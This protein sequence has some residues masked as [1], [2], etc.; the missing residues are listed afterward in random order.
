MDLKISTGMKLNQN[1]NIF[2][3]VSL[4]LVAGILRGSKYSEPEIP[5]QKIL[6]RLLPKVAI[7][8]GE[9]LVGIG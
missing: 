2:P 3:D 8:A 7:Q 4:E 9:R 6:K 1:L 5:M